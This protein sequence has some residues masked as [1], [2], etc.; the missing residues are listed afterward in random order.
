MCKVIIMRKTLIECLRSI[1]P[2]PAVETKGYITKRARAEL[3]KLPK[4]HIN[5]AL[6]IA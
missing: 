4:S 2:V 3:L 6:A 1:L 5:D